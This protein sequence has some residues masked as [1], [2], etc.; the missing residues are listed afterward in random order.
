MHCSTLVLPVPHSLP[1]F[2][3]TPVHWCYPVTSSSV[4]LFSSCL[5]SFP[6]S[7]F[8]PMSQLFTSGGQSIGASASVLP[9][10]IKGCFP[11]EG[12]TDLISKSKGLSRVLFNTT[13]RKH[14]FFSAQPSLCM[15]QLSHPYMTTG[16]N[17]ALTLLTFVGKM[18][19]L[20]FNMLSRFVIAF[21][22]RG[23]HL[24]ISWL[25]SLSAVILEP[26]KIVTV[27]S[28]C[29][30]WSDGTRS[31]DLSLLNVEF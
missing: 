31:H 24:L 23:K 12:L 2:A 20:L 26:M 22:P 27:F 19:T 25:Q 9:M 11:L 8:F 10:N 3:Q 18:T 4:A 16:K 21:L 7:G 5:Q 28:I 30:L 29:L 15:V 14:Q 1:E 6:A 17:I 13:V